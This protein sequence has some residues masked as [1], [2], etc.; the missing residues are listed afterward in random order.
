MGLESRA[1]PRKHSCFLVMFL[2]AGFLIFISSCASYKL[3]GAFSHE[4]EELEKGI[5]PGAR[6][7]IEKAYEDINIDR[8]VDYHVHIL[9]LGKGGT[10]V[11]VNPD[12]QNWLHPIQRWKFGL[13]LSAAG[14]RNIENADREY[15]SRLV[16]LIEGSRGKGKYHILAFDKNYRLDGTV[17]L[18]KTQ[19]YIPNDY[20]SKLAKEFPQYFIPVI[21]VH[22]YRPDA[23]AELE[24]WARQG[25][26]FV[27]WLPNAMGIDPSDSR[28]DLF[29][30]VMKRYNMILLSHTGE[31]QALEAEE[32]QR[33]G[34]PLLLRRPLDYGIRV[35]MAHC[36]SL[37]TCIDLDDAQQKLVSCFQLFMRMMD[38]KRY[39]GLLFGEISAQLQFNRLS[40]PI[41]TILKRRDLHHRLVNGSDYPLPA[42]NILLRTR[43]LVKDGFLTTKERIYLNEIYDYNPLLFDFVLKRTVKLPSTDQRLSPSVFQSNPGLDTSTGLTHR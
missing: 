8:L 39:E 42:I 10:N 7:L 34:N 23:L 17:N 1:I 19:F 36:G 14:I 24:K 32:D 29:Y 26:R 37:G 41:E 27:K 13:Y 35:I 15:V 16:R 33:L 31:E 3:G 22:P 30:M 18:T 6:V 38:E 25:V 9:G 5:S 20:V 43:D 2:G 28:I 12:M 4:P 11:F 21:S 40:V